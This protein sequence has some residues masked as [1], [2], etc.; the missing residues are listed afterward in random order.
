MPD[1]P[2]PL[3]ARTVSIRCQ[4]AG[5]I[6]LDD[7]LG[8]QGGL[9]VLSP[10]RRAK[11]EREIEETGF[12]F[13]F[14]IWREPGKTGER[15]RHL[16]DGHQR[17]LT[18]RYMRDEKGWVVP[19]LPFD[20][21]DADTKQE[22]MRR[23]L[24]STSQYGMVTAD[25]FRVFLEDSGIGVREYQERYRLPELDDSEDG[26]RLLS[27]LSGGDEGLPAFKPSSAEEQGK[28]DVKA[29]I[30]CPKCGESFTP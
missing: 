13:P 14:H 17:S 6:E 16:I 29:P 15:V 19:P 20:W 1:T 7:L 27:E 30:T 8:L 24:Q 28:L 25:G 12:A 22:A 18:L 9:K 5:L 3:E 4:G 21:V 23:V 11:L 2:S 26:K 10:E